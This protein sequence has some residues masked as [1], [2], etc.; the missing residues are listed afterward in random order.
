MGDMFVTSSP[1]VVVVVAAAVSQD[2]LVALRRCSGVNRCVECC[3]E[4]RARVCVYVYV[5]SRAFF[6]LRP[7]REVRTDTSNTSAV[8]YY[9]L[10]DLYP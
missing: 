2:G 5:S 10:S 9:P 1:R 4:D 6:F 3:R 7:L 8:S